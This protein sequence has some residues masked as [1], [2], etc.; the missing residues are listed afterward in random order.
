M[1]IIAPQRACEC[2]INTSY[3]RLRF[4]TYDTPAVSRVFNS[5]S[6]MRER[7]LEKI[8]KTDEQWACWTLCA[9]QIRQIPE[10]GRDAPV[11]M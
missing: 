6:K 3:E 4:V 1:F 10:E 9:L 7:E 5:S 8:D 11:V 2:T